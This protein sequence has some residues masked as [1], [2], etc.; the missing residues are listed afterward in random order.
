VNERAKA[1]FHFQGCWE[2]REMLGRRAYDEREL[3]EHLEEVPIDS[4][5]FHTHSVFLRERTLPGAYPNEFATWAAIQVRDRVLGEK[6]GVLDPRD[7]PDLE[8]LRIELV[9]LIEDH[10]SHLGSVPRVIFGEP[11]Y[12]MQSRIIE[13]PTGI[14]VRSLPEFRDVVAGIDLTAVYVHVVEAQ[15]RKGRRR[16]DF[17]AWL[18]EQL[19]RTEL[20][21]AVA[22]LNPAPLGL[23]AVRRRLVAL[24]DEAL[25]GGG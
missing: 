1:P 22:R 16:N 20:A 9:S 7:V 3:L 10:L 4:V 17:A 14:K 13:I 19:G 2:L 21:A 23:E 5:Y 18:D 24:C 11:F 25:A 12:F 8:T 15:G 6:L